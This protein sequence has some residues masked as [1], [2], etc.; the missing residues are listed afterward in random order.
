MLLMLGKKRNKRADMA[1]VVLVFLTIILYSLTLYIFNI[2]SNKI[3]LEIVD[4]KVLDSVYVREE[5][6]D[7]YINQIIDKIVSKSTNKENFIVN[8]NNE[9]DR[10]VGVLEEELIEKIKK[11]I[12]KSNFVE[13]EIIFNLSLRL[14]ENYNDRIKISYIYEK[15]FRKI[16]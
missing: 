8:F 15:E 7:F 4:A 5:K 2:N 3:S 12:L 9:I 1:V 14:D 13:E 11:S 6:L 10:Y 16:I